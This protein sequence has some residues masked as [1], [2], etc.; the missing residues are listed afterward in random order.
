MFTRSYSY[1][2]PDMA[3]LV[4]YATCD[5][6]LIEIQS[7]GK[8]PAIC[9]DGSSFRAAY[10]ACQSCLYA[11]L[12]SQFLIDFITKFYLDSVDFCDAQAP[13]PVAEPEFSSSLS[14]SSSSS[15]PPYP[16]ATGKQLTS[17]PT[18][19]TASS[20]TTSISN[21][22]ANSNYPFG[23]WLEYTFVP[24][25]TRTANPAFTYPSECVPIDYS[26]G[27]P[28]GYLCTPPQV[29]CDL[30]VGPPV[31][32]YLCS[33]DDCR[34]A[35]SFAGFPQS[36]QTTNSTQFEFSPLPLPTGFFNL[37]PVIFGADWGI[38]TGDVSITSTSGRATSTTA[39]NASTSATSS[40]S[41]SPS[42]SPATDSSNN[43]WIAGPVV[44]SVAAVAILGLAVLYLL[45][46]RRHRRASDRTETHEKAQLDS[47]EVKP[48]E[49]GGNEIKEIEGRNV[50]PVEMDAGYAGAEMETTGTGEDAQVQEI[51]QGRRT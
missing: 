21:I 25:P 30:E 5:K 50:L 2:L 10:E 49:A 26:W 22:T 24:C 29:D 46:R 42:Q 41:P 19:T 27:C 51:G 36:N 31:N 28:P 45:R 44:G 38:F 39:S 40:P 23:F 3:L 7:V 32:E 8:A 12:G 9:G 1:N 15:C 13:T 18:R 43:R 17:S 35:P 6:V 37:N 4:C 48:K 11:N 16:T 34:I 14:S 47:T 20:I 33:P